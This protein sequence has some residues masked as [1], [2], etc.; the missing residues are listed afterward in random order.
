MNYLNKAKKSVHK[1][2]T[3]LALGLSVLGILWL[4]YDY[5]LD[6]VIEMIVAG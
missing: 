2:I 1:H 4:A 6:K 5:R 3:P